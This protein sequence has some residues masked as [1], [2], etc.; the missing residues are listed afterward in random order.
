MK[1]P[2]LLILMLMFSNSSFSQ[3]SVLHF[4]IEAQTT[5]TS[6]DQV[7]FW[8]RSNQYGSIPISGAS[9][10]FIGRFRK[11]YKGDSNKLIDWGVGFEGRTNLGYTSQGLLLEAYGKLRV[12][13]FELKAGRSKDMMGLVGDSSLSSGS[14]GISGN[15]LG[16]PEVRLSVPEYYK[17]PLFNGLFS[18]KGSLAHGWLGDVPMVGYRVESLPTFFHQSSFYARIGKSNCRLKLYG[19]INHQAF[20]GNPNA[21]YGP[22]QFHF[23][24]LQEYWAVMTSQIVYNS[25]I[26]NHL[27]S[28]DLG[29][30]YRFA[31]LILKAYRENIYD[32]KAL[33]RL[34]NLKDGLNGLTI[35]NT[36]SP[37]RDRLHWRTI[38]FELLYTNNQ[39]AG[40]LKNMVFGP[41]NY[42][43]NHQYP[44]GWSYRGS[45][46]GTSFITTRQYVREN[47]S[48]LTSND[49]VNNRVQVFHLGI[50]GSLNDIIFTAKISYSK[51]Y[52]VYGTTN[53]LVD[54]NTRNEADRIKFN[55]QKQLST[56]FEFHKIFKNKV[57]L[58][59]M[60]AFDHGQLLYNSAAL[61]A[62]ISK[63]L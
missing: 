30:D 53:R 8:L 19:G 61:Q 1:V 28:V 57:N 37:E 27:G 20:W 41:E 33:F 29:F 11:D 14:F 7:P 2:T 5:Y 3:D 22:G 31:G 26:G 24:F 44:E 47:L 21:Y 18:I 62:C 49:F 13:V 43:I 40:G 16:I 38:L 59:L 39:A 58:G 15:A 48:S 50:E 55:L 52:G 63:S 34:A 35:V 17:L 51:N 12:G 36:K 23:S 56:Y 9:S 10:S 25:R 45:N 4:N 46:L 32:Y 42:Y 60:L 54:L 6:N